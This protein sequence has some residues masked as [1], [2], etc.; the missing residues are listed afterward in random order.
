M[1]FNPCQTLGWY[2]IVQRK[3]DINIQHFGGKTLKKRPSGKPGQS[4]TFVISGFYRNIDEKC[5][6]LGCYT[7]CSSNPLPMHRD[8]LLAP[9]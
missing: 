6:L 2:Q 3:E 1:Y 5:A 9:S 8:N 7:V 4:E